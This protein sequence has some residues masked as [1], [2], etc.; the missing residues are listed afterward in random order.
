MSKTVANQR[1]YSDATSGVWMSLPGTALPTT[2]TAAYGAGWYELGLLTDKGVIETFSRTATPSWNWQGNSQGRTLYTQ[3]TGS[4]QIEANEENSHVLRLARPGS[5]VTTTGGTAEVQ[6][7]TFTGTGTAGTWTATWNALTASGLAYNITTTAL[8]T[9]LSAAWGITVTVTGTA[10]SSYVVTF[11]A[12]NGNVT[13]ITT[14]NAVT[15][16][17]AITVVETT[18]G[19]NPI[20]TTNI[21]AYTGTDYFQFGIDLVDGSVHKRYIVPNADAVRTGTVSYVASALTVYAFTINCY[22]DSNGNLA[23]DINDNPALSG[24]I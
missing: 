17:T 14:T 12:A 9:A 23:I 8:A 15:G 10:G 19:V 3:P 20:N 1:S 6:T 4:F 24:T 7:I 11:P 5:T 22:P 16:V 2:P 18:P 13:L 21:K